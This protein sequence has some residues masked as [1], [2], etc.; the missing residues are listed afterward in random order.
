V[1]ERPCTGADVAALLGV[2]KQA[3]SKLVDA[4]AHGGYVARRTHGS[5]GRAKVVALTAR[6]RRFLATVE[7][8]YA[9]LEAEWA[10]VTSHRR[11]ETLRAE[12]VTVLEVA[13][14]G[15]LPAVRPA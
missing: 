14:G 3:A 13:Y 6:G 7:E 12:L 4:M 2:S 15:R 1:R 8:I 5:D 10:R 11:L 9:E